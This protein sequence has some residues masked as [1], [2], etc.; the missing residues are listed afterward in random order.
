[1][2][3][4]NSPAM[5]GQELEEHTIYFQL[6]N[7]GARLACGVRLKAASR[8][9]AQHYFRENWSEIESMARRHIA[10]GG[11]AAGLLAMPVTACV[12]SDVTASDN[13]E[14]RSP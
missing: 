7:A 1:M 13:I 9:D 3:R 6:S 8:D 5:P 2:R 10:G 14:G 4:E 12:A 11:D